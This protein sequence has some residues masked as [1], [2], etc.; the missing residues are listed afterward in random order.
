MPAKDIYHETVKKVLIKDGWV[1][2]HEP[3]P[4]KWGR[5]D[6]YVDLGA[7]KLLLAEKTGRKIAVE[8]KSFVSPSEIEDLKNALGSYLLY[9]DVLEQIEP[10]RELYL[11]IRKAVYFDLFEESIGQLLLQHH[12]VRILVFDQHHE[13]VVQWIP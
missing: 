4:L 9:S 5:K 6:L 12:H 8:V 2:T 3:L 1:I 10:D 13:E 7:E 11:A